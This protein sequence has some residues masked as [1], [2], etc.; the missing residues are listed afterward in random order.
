MAIN[1]QLVGKVAS[2]LTGKACIIRQRLP[3][4]RGIDALVQR[5]K[6]TGRPVIDINPALEEGLYLR[7]LLHELAHVA[8]E[9]GSMAPTDYTTLPPASVTPTR[10]YI[11]DQ[12][13]RPEE[14]EAE[15]L[16]GQW[17]EY[18]ER[19]A[20]KAGSLESKLT[21][22]LGWFPDDLQTIIDNAVRTAIT[23]TRKGTR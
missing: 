23:Q 18:A 7:Y 10:Q 14:G 15:R 5:D 13:T 16:A 4:L 9:W 20:G 2:R 1:R 22:L 12:A 21:A 6:L 11:T 17:L 8:R 19:R 3:Y